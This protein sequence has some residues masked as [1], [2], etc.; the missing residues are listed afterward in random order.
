MNGWSL[1]EGNNASWNDQIKK[2]KRSS[3]LQDNEWALNLQALSW[4]VCRWSYKKNDESIAY[5]QGF[6]KRYPFGVGVLWF[7]DWIV[8]DYEQSLGLIKVIK[9]S[10][11]LRFL[12]IRIR[13]HHQKNQR[14]FD[15]L[16]TVFSPAIRPFGSALRMNLSLSISVDQ[17]H[18]NLS[19]NWKRNLKRSNKIDHEIIE[20]NNPLIIH[21]L[22]K[23]LSD[24]KKTRQ[25]Y[26]LQEIESLMRSHQDRILV[27]GSKTSDGSVQAIRG[28]IIRGR[29]AIDIFA[30]ASHFSRKHY[31]SYGLCW[32]LIVRCKD[33]GCIDY[34][35][36]G[37]DPDKNKGVYN[38]KKGTGAEMVE[39][40]GEFE[41]SNSYLL[42]W[43]LILL[44][45]LR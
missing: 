13:S 16:S 24:L 10:L 15:I 44:S 41:Y 29:K 8:G 37:V 11:S 42:K 20:I 4:V 1:Y 36:S 22:Y 26:T 28:A 45:F 9:E 19:K 18:S 32:E 25:F 12:T 17:L 2:F 23:E 34:D 31:L 3:Y 38:F 5:L 43:I 6:L 14:E 7:P 33:L 27:I 35:F 30:A 21:S 39:M 40:L